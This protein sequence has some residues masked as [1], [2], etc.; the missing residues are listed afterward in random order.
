MGLFLEEKKPE[1]KPEPQV[2]KQDWLAVLIDKSFAFVTLVTVGLATLYWHVL[3]PLLTIEGKTRQQLSVHLPIAAVLIMVPL[4]GV[5]LIPQVRDFVSLSSTRT[6]NLSN[7]DRISFPSRSFFMV[8]VQRRG[9]KFGNK[10]YISYAGYAEGTPQ[11][12]GKGQCQMVPRGEKIRL[13][14]VDPPTNAEGFKA[15]VGYVIRKEIDDLSGTDYFFEWIKHPGLWL[16]TWKLERT[17]VDVSKDS[18]WEEFVDD[19]DD[20]REESGEYRSFE[21][22]ALAREH[23]VI[24]F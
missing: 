1:P 14:S 4:Y 16:D 12:I 8:D 10:T 22:R 19:W 15:K 2:I 9:G 7:G 24:C 6:I 11:P 18:S 21:V 17:V 23:A 13:V 20:I 5:Y 3:K